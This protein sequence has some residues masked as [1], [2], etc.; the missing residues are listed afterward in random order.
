MEHQKSRHSLVVQELSERCR[1]E[2]E[3]WGLKISG[4]DFGS[5][6]EDS[7]GTVPDVWLY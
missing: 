1:K 6:A 2:G 5:E 7:D 4:S 3:E